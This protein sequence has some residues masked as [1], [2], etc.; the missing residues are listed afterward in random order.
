SLSGVAQFRRPRWPLWALG[1]AGL[2]VAAGVMAGFVGFLAKRELIDV[3]A[4]AGAALTMAALAVDDLRAARRPAWRAHVHRMLAVGWFY[5]A[6]LMIFV[7]DPHPSLIA[8]AAAAVV[9]TA[10]L[11]WMRW[12]PGD[13]A[14]GGRAPVARVAA[15]RG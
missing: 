13:F 11:A 9:P 4:F 6:E 5:V 3:A 15:H 1:V 8:W 14:D 7:F 12:R 10:V 2:L